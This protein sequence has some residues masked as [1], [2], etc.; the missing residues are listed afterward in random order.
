MVKTYKVME[1]H[2]RYEKLSNVEYTPMHKNEGINLL[3]R[4]G[5]H[6]HKVS[7]L[8]G[9]RVSKRKTYKE[10][11]YGSPFYQIDLIWGL[12]LPTKVEVA[13]KFG[14]VDQDWVKFFTE[15]RKNQDVPHSTEH[16]Y[17]FDEEGYIMVLPKIVLYF[18]DGSTET[19]RFY[20]EDKAVAFFEKFKSN[21]THEL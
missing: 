18:L 9:E 21:L 8:F 1:K 3:F 4:K 14:I 19:Y 5:E 6:V 12:D 17:M 11:V 20:T 2:I 13:K 16:K 10:D 15:I 7:S